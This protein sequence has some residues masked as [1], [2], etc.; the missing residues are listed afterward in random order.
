MIVAS[1]FLSR[2]HS[3]PFRCLLLAIH[4]YG[5]ICPYFCYY[6]P[7]GSVW[8]CA[9]QFKTFFFQYRNGTIT[10]WRNNL[11]SFFQCESRALSRDIRDYF[12]ATSLCS[13][14]H[15]KKARINKKWTQGFDFDRLLLRNLRQ[16]FLPPWGVT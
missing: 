8:K 2:S 11:K 3:C 12:C 10:Q 7:F 14:G 16:F 9:S 15:Q 5:Y 4:N 6:L 1:N 13:R